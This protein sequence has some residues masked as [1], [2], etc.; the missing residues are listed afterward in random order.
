MTVVATVRIHVTIVRIHVTIVL[1]T[2]QTDQSIIM[3]LLAGYRKTVD[4]SVV[5]HSSIEFDR[6]LLTSGMI[7]CLLLTD[8]FWHRIL[9]SISLIS[10]TLHSRFSAVIQQC[11]RNRGDAKSKIQSTW[12]EP[13]TASMTRWYQNHDSCNWICFQGSTGCLESNVSV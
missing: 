5:V 8:I 3:M 1:A 4:K 11:D 2:G 7:H 6:R 9:E 12:V 13:S 10:L